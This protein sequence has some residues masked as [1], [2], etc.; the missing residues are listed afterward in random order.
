LVVLALIV[1]LIFAVAH[2]ATKP[3]ARATATAYCAAAKAGNYPKAYTTFAPVLQTLV[4]S[5]AYPAG[6]GAVDA[7]QGKVTACDLGKLTVAKDGKSATLAVTVT[8]QKIGKQAFTWQFAQV[9]TDVWRFIAA[10]D[11]AVVPLTV[12]TLYCSDMQAGKLGDVYALFTPNEQQSVG[13]IAQFT[14]DL[15]QTSKVVGTLQRCQ[16]QKITASKDGKTITLKLGIWFSNVQNAPGEIALKLGTDGAAKID[17]VS[18]YVAGKPVPYPPP[19]SLL[20][21]ILQ[22]LGTLTGAGS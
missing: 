13:D 21:Q 15:S 22:L 16:L 14:Q 20:Q 18:V 4:A 19:V 17:G 7:I 6:A 11:A 5:T 2:A 3:D 8:R 12:A 10:P 9:Q 1:S